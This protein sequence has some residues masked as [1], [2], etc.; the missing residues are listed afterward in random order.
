MAQKKQTRKAGLPKFKLHAKSAII[1]GV[2]SVVLVVGAVY[3]YNTMSSASA[4]YV[5]GWGCN[6][7]PTLRKGSKG[8]CVK[9]V[10]N[11]IN[12]KVLKPCYGYTVAT[13]GVFGAKTHEGVAKFQSKFG[14]RADGIVGGNTWNA[15]VNGSHQCITAGSKG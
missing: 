5:S 4:L 14:L 7:T 6:S 8:A 3:L 12:A 2:V 13:D 10:Q 15:I 1:G 11:V 9:Y